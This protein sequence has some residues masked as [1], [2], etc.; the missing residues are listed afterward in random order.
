MHSKNPIPTFFLLTAVLCLLSAL[1]ASADE[2]TTVSI[3]RSNI[4]WHP[5]IP[6]AGYHLMISGPNGLSK[7]AF[8]A[9]ETPSFSVFDGE[10]FALADG[11][12]TWE[13]RAK[14][15]GERQSSVQWGYFVIEG[16]AFVT[17]NGLGSQPLRRDTCPHVETGNALLE[18]SMCFGLGCT[19][20]PTFGD[21]TIILKEAV[22]QILFQDTTTDAN[23]WA[24]SGDADK[25]TLEDVDATTTPITIEATAPSNSLYV[26]DAGRI[27]L[28]TATPDSQ[29]HIVGD[30]SNG[31]GT[32]KIEAVSGAPGNIL[33]LE[34]DTD[35]GG[36]IAFDDGDK[37]VAGGGAGDTFTLSEAG[38]AAEFILTNSGNLTI[39][40]TLTENSDVNVK[41]NFS[42]ID[43]QQFLR[44]AKQLPISTWN[45][46]EDDELARHLG[47]MAQDFYSS[48]GLGGT[49]TGIAPRNLAAVAL[50]ALQGLDQVVEERT[51]QL[52]Q[53]NAALAERLA[54]LEAKINAMTQD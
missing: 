28:G 37:W 44:L 27:G 8:T 15:T 5:N 20:C 35:N 10:G 11:Q 40:G 53:E 52:Q 2:S 9:E 32:V 50:A 19:S 26:D 41:E 29:L 17:N 24:L 7:Y 43:P 51:A 18:G 13:L 21:N 46:K 25:F 38:D 34:T 48:F 54:A 22:P 33:E 31:L 3:E 47:P 36:R 42:A 23:D 30:V 4:T 14:Q 39:T 49:N 12:Y 1:G 16:G 6:A 45:Y